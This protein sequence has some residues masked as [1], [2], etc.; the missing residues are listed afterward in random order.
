[1]VLYSMPMSRT[2]FSMR[3]GEVAALELFHDMAERVP[4]YKDFLLNHGVDHS[5]I[6]TIDDFKSL[7][8]VDKK[9]YLTKYPLSELCWDGKLTSNYMVSVSSGSSGSSFFWPRG[10]DQDDEGTLMHK[11]MFDTIFATHRKK[12]LLIVCFSMGTWIAGSFTTASAIGVAKTGEPLTIVTPGLEKIDAIK[13][14]KQLA[15]LYDQVILA[16]YPPFLKDVIEDGA[17]EGVNWRKHEVKLLTAGEAF[18]EEW[19]SY[20]LR[21]LGSKNPYMDSV[22]IYGSA[23]AAMLGHET[24]ASIALRRLYNKKKRLRRTMFGTDILPSILQF[25][26]KRRFFE[27]VDGELVFSARAG[28]PLTRYNIHD[29]G[30]VYEYDELLAPIKTQHD[31]LLNAYGVTRTWQQ[32]FVYLNGRKDFTATIYA[33]NIYPENIKSALLGRS[34]AKWVTGRFTMAT[35]YYSDMDQYLEINIELQR[36]IIAKQD[37]ARQVE[38]VVVMKLCLLNAEFRKLFA[39]IGSKA[40]PRINLITYGEP[41]YFGRGIKHTWVK[42]KS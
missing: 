10:L 16:G 38:E 14:F 27:A 8:L 4:A 19:R 22:S 18:S 24:P 17:R 25:D 13:C 6:R 39:A 3:S 5:T 40:A 2:D 36:D 26:P 29:T 37:M 32:P 9:N 11:D 7:P 12:T 41:T 15:H 34:V 31:A 30:G 21:E 42:K 35:K 20:V 33:V 28:I 1:M 23:D